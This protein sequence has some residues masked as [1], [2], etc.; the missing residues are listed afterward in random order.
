VSTAAATPTRLRIG[1]HEPTSLDSTAMALLEVRDLSKSFGETRALTSCSLTA[2]QGQVYA[3]LGENGS[4]KSTLVKILSG[5]IV[6]DGGELRI[7]SSRMT[8]FSP[9]AARAAGV[10]PVLQEVL[11]AP[12]RTVVDNIFLGHD[13]FVRRSLSRAERREHAQVALARITS[14]PPNLDAFVGDLALSQR[15]LVT[16]ARALVRDPRVLILDEATSALDIGDRR[17]LFDAIRELV[18]AGSLVIFISHRLDEVMEISDVVTVLRNGMSTET[19]RRGEFDVHH[20]LRLMSPT[21]ADRL[22]RE[23]EVDV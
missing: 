9:S 13:P 22:E 5:V 4:G 21:G 16:I 10:A 1:L 12:N 7:A 14:A 20:L 19:V 6:P 23:H 3:V 18:A 2:E 15:Q 11:V 17:I 8:H